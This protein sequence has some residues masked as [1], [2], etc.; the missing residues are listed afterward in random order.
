MGRIYNYYLF[1]ILM[2]LSCVANAQD[3]AEESSYKR[4][5]YGGLNMNTNGGLLSGA[6]LKYSVRSKKKNDLYHSFYLEI[7][8]VKHP[9]EVKVSTLQNS[10]TYI[11][12]KENYLFPIRLMYGREYLLFKKAKDEGIHLNGVIACGPTFGIV[13]P[14]LVQFGADIDTAKPTQN[15]DKLDPNMI[16]GSS[17]F[18]TGFDVAT[19]EMGACVKTGL[20]F[21]FGDSGSMTGVELGFLFEAFNKKIELMPNEYAVNK[22]FFTSAYAIIFF[23]GRN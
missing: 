2:S 22:Q 19:L 1:F 9:K 6:T 14:Y 17:G 23:G 3:A 10:S 13:K 18:F 5:F 15:S 12:N 11:L 7:V 4:E 21:E 8:N 20:S 16:Y